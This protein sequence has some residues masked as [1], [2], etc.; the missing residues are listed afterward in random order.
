MKSHKIWLCEWS[1]LFIFLFFLTWDAG[2]DIAIALSHSFFMVRFPSLPSSV[3]GHEK[4]WHE[5]KKQNEQ[6]QR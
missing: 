5:K 1:V 3:S 4:S 2:R 6:Q